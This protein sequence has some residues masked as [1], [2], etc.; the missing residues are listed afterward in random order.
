ML[1]EHIKYDSYAKSKEIHIK[2]YK[3]LLDSESNFDIFDIKQ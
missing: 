3:K 1:L 2:L